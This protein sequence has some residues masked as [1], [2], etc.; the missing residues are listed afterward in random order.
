MDGCP[1]ARSCIRRVRL[2]VPGSLRH[3]R[4]LQA[5]AGARRA[6]RRAR[7]SSSWR[8]RRSPTSCRCAARTDG[9]S[10]RGCVQLAGTAKTGLRALMEVSGTDPSALNAQALGFRLAPRINA[11]GRLAR[12]DAGLELLLTR[13]RRPRARDRRRTRRAS[14]GSGA[15]SRSGSASPRRRWSASWANAAPTSSPGTDWHPGVIGI[16]ASRVV[17]RYHRPAILIALDGDGPAQGSGRSIP[18]FDL[19]AALDSCAEHLLR[20]GGHRAAAGLTSSRHASSS[21]SAI[22]SA[23]GA[24]CSARTARAGGARRRGRLRRAARPAARPRSSSDWSRAGWAT[25]P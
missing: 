1:T 3:R 13:R 8:S 25:R 21:A 16:V 2:P 17:E 19:L 7:T 11:A 6:E 24:R 15:R 12:A 20:Y 10:A 14:T 18:G 23:R 22:R 5:R 4:R 9:S